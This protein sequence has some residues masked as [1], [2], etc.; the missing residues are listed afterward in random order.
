MGGL[1]AL[2]V[3]KY[4]NKKFKK[5]ATLD[6]QVMCKL[7]VSRKSIPD[8]LI[9]TISNLW[10]EVEKS[11][12]NSFK[13]DESLISYLNLKERSAFIDDVEELKRLMEHHNVIKT[14]SL[15][16]PGGFVL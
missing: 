14:I 10:E 9:Q 1:H 3:E 13:I 4:F 15:I 7:W 8:S 6:A 11:F 16:Q 2:Y 5:V 12:G